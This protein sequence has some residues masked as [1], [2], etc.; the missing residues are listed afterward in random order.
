MRLREG[1][2]T[3]VALFTP[4]LP[5]IRKDNPILARSNGEALYAP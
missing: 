4:D 3:R 2:R 5:S 1:V